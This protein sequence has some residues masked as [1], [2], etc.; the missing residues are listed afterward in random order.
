MKLSIKGSPSEP[1]LELSLSGAT[2]NQEQI[3]FSA[4]QNDSPSMHH[5]AWITPSGEFYLHREAI[6]RIGLK[7][8]NYT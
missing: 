8:K 5:L 7:L 6:E 1:T 4:R 2:F 3:N